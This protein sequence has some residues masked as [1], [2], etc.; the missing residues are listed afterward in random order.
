VIG[1]DTNVLV[2]YLTQD[3]PRQGRRAS[4]LVTE[5]AAAGERLFVTSEVVCELVWVLRGAYGLERRAIGATLEQILATA[6]IEVD[7][8]DLV[9]Q[10]LEDYR[11]GTGDFADYLIGRR[12]QEAGCERTATF[13]RRLKASHL[14]QVLSA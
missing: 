5:V 1:L 8:K 2:R 3:D 13:D 4:A 6:Q 7:R 14:F 10:A 9:R 12:C 11:G